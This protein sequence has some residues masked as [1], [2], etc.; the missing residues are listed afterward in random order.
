MGQDFYCDSRQKTDELEIELREET[1]IL[2]VHKLSNLL[3][4]TDPLLDLKSSFNS[5]RGSRFERKFF[6]F[7]IFVESWTEEPF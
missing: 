7:R 6:R 1:S 4:A 3:Q 2:A 5:L